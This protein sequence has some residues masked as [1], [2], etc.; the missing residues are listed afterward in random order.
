[1]T[2]LLVTAGFASA[3]SPLADALNPFSKQTTSIDRDSVEEALNAAEGKLINTEYFDAAQSFKEV[4]SVIEATEGEYSPEL[5]EALFGLGQ[6]QQSLGD[7]TAALDAYQRGQHI[8][9]RTEG[10]HSLTQLKFLD[11][12]IEIS[13]NQEEAMD[14]DKLQ[15][16]AL[17][18]AE[19]SFGSADMRL[20]PHLDRLGKWFMETGQF[21]QAKKSFEQMEKIVEDGQGEYS[22]QLIEPLRRLAMNKRLKGTCCAY[23]PLLKVVEIIDRNPEISK[24]DKADIYTE[25]ADAYLIHRKRKEAAI[26]YSKA[27]QQLTAEEATERFEQPQ[28]LV[29]TELLDE[30]A[31]RKMETFKVNRN[32]PFDRYR[33][34]PERNPEMFPDQKPKQFRVPPQNFE[35]HIL[36]RDPIEFALHDDKEKSLEVIGEPVQFIFKQLQYILPLSLQSRS[37]LVDISLEF[38]FIVN[39]RGN[40]SKVNLVSSNAPSKINRIMK[41]VIRKSKFRPRLVDGRPVTTDN[42]YLTQTFNDETTPE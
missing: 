18:I 19:Q 5:V 41:E 3:S 16:L 28:Q 29:M 13:L 15:R 1:M 37:D 10:V 40:T 24:A 9:H 4:I 30:A 42:V 34:T 36:I 25:I 6:S 22:T 27:W 12:L 33:M 21:H 31:S 17:Y 39:D 38:E 14:A 20:I 26:Y 8:I 11:E 32:D 7:L 35:Y 2:M 23:K